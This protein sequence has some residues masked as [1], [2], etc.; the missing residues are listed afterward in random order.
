ME[1]RTL[2]RT[3][4]EVSAIGF[5]CGNT[6]G[7]MV[8]GAP[9]E[10]RAAV[11]RALAG[12]ITYFDTAAQYGE[13]RSEEN[14]G[15]VLR[16]LGADVLVGTKVR[17]V[18]EE[19][20]DAAGA[21]RRKLEEGL[22]RLGRE[23]VDVC[24]LHNPTLL[25]AGPRGLPVEAVLGAVGEGMQALR[26]AG[27]C[28]FV[29]FSALGDTPALQRVATAG[30]F[31]TC[32]CYYNALNPSAGYPGSP[33]GVAQ[34]FA[35]L[36]DRAAA[37]GLGVFAIRI[38][39]GGAAIATPERHPTAGAGSALA[40]GTEYDRD[41]AQAAG[42]RVLAAELGLESPLELALRFALAKAG[43]SCLLIGPSS[44]AHVE[45]ALRWEARGPLPPDAV[46]RVLA[47]A[48]RPAA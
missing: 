30:I 40:Q 11:A 42:L 41:V 37:A 38:L 35:G 25:D 7:L 45:D 5:G 47:L 12:G 31:D 8:R 6:G 20:P 1:Y 23:Q 13:G 17:L 29:G 10:Q 22:R 43:I 32:Q 46:A 33:D 19:V 48:R 26:A 27:L 9:A 14:L 2:G 18:P 15:R 3:G 28:R 16:E 44:V 39:A 21:L 4:L 24:T 36:L 34:D